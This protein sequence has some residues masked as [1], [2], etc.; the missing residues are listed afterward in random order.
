MNPFNGRKLIDGGK[1]QG[2]QTTDRLPVPVHE[3]LKQ[4]LDLYEANRGDNLDFRQLISGLTEILLGE[5]KLDIITSHKSPESQVGVLGFAE[6]LKRALRTANARGVVEY[7]SLLTDAI[8]LLDTLISQIGSNSDSNFEPNV[9]SYIHRIEGDNR[10]QKLYLACFF[11]NALINKVTSS[12][13]ELQSRDDLK[14]LNEIITNIGEA[15]QNSLHNL[16]FNL[17]RD[18]FIQ[19]AWLC[20]FEEIKKNL[21]LNPKIKLLK[22]IAGV[23]LILFILLSKGGEANSSN[24]KPDIIHPFEPQPWSAVVFEQ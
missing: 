8:Q 22:L 20:M 17:S 6:K 24:G 9:T 12:Y 3:Q 19:S 23:S 16:G 4:I 1:D 18:E 5:I 7:T 14:T 21:S 10:V 13:D 15:I 2:S 11:L